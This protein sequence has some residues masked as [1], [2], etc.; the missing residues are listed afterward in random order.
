MSKP[1]WQSARRNQPVGPYH[2]AQELPARPPRKHRSDVRARHPSGGG[3]HRRRRRLQPRQFGAHRDAGGGRR[4][5]AH[6]LQER[7]HDDVDPARHEGD[8]LLPG[9]VQPPRGGQPDDHADLHHDRR[10]G[11]DHHGVRHRHNVVHEADGLSAAQRR[12]E[13]DRQMGQFAPAGCARARQHRLDGRRRQDQ[14]AQDRDQQPA[15]AAQERR[16]QQWRRVCVHRS[17]REGRECRLQQLHFELGRLD[18]L[19]RQ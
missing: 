8:I 7:V 12:D 5:R 10:L 4:D 1:C 14:R 3:I 13:L 15:H 2:A 6:A 19:E 9:T 17:V 16:H 18:R 11:A